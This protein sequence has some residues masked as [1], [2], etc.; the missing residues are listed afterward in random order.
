MYLMHLNCFFLTGNQIPERLL[1]RQLREHDLYWSSYRRWLPKHRICRHVEHRIRLGREE[2]HVLPAL[3]TAALEDDPSLRLRAVLHGVP[4]VGVHRHRRRR[5]A[6]ERAV[7]EDDVAVDPQDVDRVALDV[8][9]E[10]V[11]EADVPVL[12]ALDVAPVVVLAELDARALLTA[13]DRVLHRLAALVEIRPVP[14]RGHRRKRQQNRNRFHR[15]TL[16]ESEEPDCLRRKLDLRAP[17]ADR[18]DESVH[19][20]LELRRGRVDRE[21]DLLRLAR[22]IEDGHVGRARL[23]AELLDVHARVVA[24]REPADGTPPR[25]GDRA[26]ERHVLL[27]ERTIPLVQVRIVEVVPRR[28]VRAEEAGQ[29]AVGEGVAHV[30]LGHVLRPLREVGVHQVAVGLRAAED[31]AV[32]DEVIRDRLPA[33]TRLRL[34]VPGVP[35]RLGA[36]HV[37]VGRHPRPAARRAVRHRRSFACTDA[38]RRRFRRTHS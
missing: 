18:E 27:E 7:R 1:F 28:G 6:A 32:H 20:V 38:C 36:H 3:E 19:E 22:G 9:E 15:V 14:V 23:A 12:P 35:V 30:A 17:V 24:G 11:L 37:E 13:A 4:V 26:A 8:L 2:R 33:G 16:L 10:R 5:G 31:A 29:H 21:R 25:G 34:R